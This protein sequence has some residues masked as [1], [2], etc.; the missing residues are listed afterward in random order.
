MRQVG[1]YES[2][3]LDTYI[4]WICSDRLYLDKEYQDAYSNLIR[5]LM[6]IEFV[7][8]IPFDENR[9]RDGLE[10][11]EDFTYET[12]QFLDKSSNLLPKCSV[13]EMLAALCW[14]CENQIMYDYDTGLHPERWFYII[15]EN[16]GLEN[17]TDSRWKRD[18][19]DYIFNA[20][21]TFMYHKY[22]KNG[23]NGGLF[24]IKKRGIDQRN[25]EIWKQM[26]AFLNENY[27]NL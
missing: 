9:A 2:A 5:T 8:S 18:T 22:H 27:I 21:H 17:C 11:R 10:L 12:D 6:E 15:L 20:V 26:N 16:L 7:W 13:F 3:S 25:N 4:D 24:P 19:R 23:S 1:N 14:R